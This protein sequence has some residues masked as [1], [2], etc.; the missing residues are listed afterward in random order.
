MKIIVTK[1]GILTIDGSEFSP[2][3]I[4]PEILENIIDKGMLDE[5]DV[6]LPGDKSHPIV[7][8]ISE[9]SELTKKDSEFR[10]KIKTLEKEKQENDKKILE[11]ETKINQEDELKNEDSGI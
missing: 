3:K 10:K 7:S 6:S 11:E 4:T 8:L 2:D 9:L 1:E 5:L